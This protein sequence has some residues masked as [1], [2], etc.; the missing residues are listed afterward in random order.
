[1]YEN[2]KGI[3]QDYVE[4]AKWYRREAEQGYIWG[5][6]NIGRCYYTGEGVPKNCVEAYKRASVASPINKMLREF[7]MGVIRRD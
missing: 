4:A 7:F 5:E 6:V 3:S 1:M 2:G